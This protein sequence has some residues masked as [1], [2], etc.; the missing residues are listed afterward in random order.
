MAWRG[1]LKETGFLNAVVDLV[2]TGVTPGR[3]ALGVVQWKVGRIRRPCFSGATVLKVPILSKLSGLSF[4][5]RF[6]VPG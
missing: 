2:R 3:E 1:G 5:Q 4:A 6:A